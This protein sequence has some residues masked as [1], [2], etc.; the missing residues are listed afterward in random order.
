M[1][2]SRLGC[3]IQWWSQPIPC[4]HSSLS[5]CI[6]FS[7]SNQPNVTTF[8]NLLFGRPQDL[9]TAS[10]N[11]RIFLLIHFLYMSKLSRSGLSGFT[12]QM[13]NM[14]LPSDV[15][16]PDLVHPAHS[17]SE[18]QQFHLRYIQNTANCLELQL[19][20]TSTYVKGSNMKIPW[21]WCN[22]AGKRTNTLWKIGYV[23]FR[24]N[25]S[26]PSFFCFWQGE[27]GR[28]VKG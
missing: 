10:S 15:L 11:L 16:I 12:S 19:Q 28:G 6:L 14:R 9:P 2:K 20:T 8:I 18:A 23:V 24:A 7:Y 17:H 13:C 21:L 26:N 4:L 25:D 3:S 27:E 5:L 22:I 1:V